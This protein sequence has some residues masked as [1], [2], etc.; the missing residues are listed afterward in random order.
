MIQFNL[1]VVCELLLSVEV[2]VNLKV[3]VVQK[4]SVRDCMVTL[5]LCRPTIV[6]PV[7]AFQ[8]VIARRAKLTTHSPHSSDGLESHINHVKPILYLVNGRLFFDL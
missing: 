5:R 3:L 1:S 6:S 4:V 8:I 2:Q 7:P